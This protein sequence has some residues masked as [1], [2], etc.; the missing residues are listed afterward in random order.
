MSEAFKI[1]KVEK[2]PDSQVAVTGELSL[3][4]LKASRTEALKEINNR[5]NLS[6]FRPG[7][8][9]EDT[10]VKTVGE[11]KVLEEVAE[12]ALGR[13]YGNIIKAAQEK[14]KIT[15]IGRP[16]VAITKLAPGIPLEFK[17]TLTLEPAFELPDYKKVA[18]EIELDKI[19]DATDKEIDDVLEEITKRD[20]KPELKEGEDLREKVKE[21]IKLEKAFRNKEKHRLQIVEWLVKATEI[22]IPP[23]L[24]DA[25]LEKMVGQFKDDVSRHGLKWEDYL[26]NIKK[27]EEEIR[28]EW[29]DKARDRAKAE[30]IVAK[31]A[32]AEKLEPKVEELES[33]SKHLLEH[34]PD[35][36]PLR[37]R[38]HVYQMLQNQKVLEFL[39]GLN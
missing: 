9:P 36:D 21:N 5:S 16:T 28:E 11:L 26:K 39:E 17:I 7:H 18:T 38:I 32:E 35:A 20:W 2:L 1:L 13:E 37:L 23:L 24:A 19:P 34:Y 14:E 30:L 15:P 33:E 8:I 10:L 12:V 3:E 31:I 25:E 22:S 27:S 29:R 4:L 6:G